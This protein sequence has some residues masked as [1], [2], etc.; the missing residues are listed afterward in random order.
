MIRFFLI[1]LFIL[2]T[3]CSKNIEFVYDDKKNLL[4]PLYGKTIVETSGLDLPFIRSYIPMFFGEKSADD[5]VL[6]ISINENK[7]K[8]SVETNQA[9]SNLEYELRFVYL[10]K[11][12]DKKCVVYK[13]EI[14]SSFTIIPKS[15]GYN[16]GTDSSLEN[17]YELAVTDS[18]NEYVS[19][20]SNV[21]LDNCL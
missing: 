13:K 4:N 15:S 14:S 19:F 20:L 7:I 12:N 10:L 2:A 11:S 1:G 5:Y 16:Y 3:S 8:R 6:S 18:L 9:T 21:D 17:K